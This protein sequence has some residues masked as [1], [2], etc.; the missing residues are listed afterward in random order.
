[1]GHLLDYRWMNQIQYYFPEAWTVGMCQN[2][3][4]SVLSLF[5]DS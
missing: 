3:E 5:W 1:M 4:L 2:L